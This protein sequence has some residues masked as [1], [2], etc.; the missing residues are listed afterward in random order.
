MSARTAVK[1]ALKR[2]AACARVDHTLSVTSGN[3]VGERIF[4][5]AQRQRDAER[6]VRTV[7]RSGL[8]D[9]RMFNELRGVQHL[10][11]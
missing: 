8:T 9:K 3:S 4:H 2:A 6:A 5:V 1:N 7:F 11:N 10:T